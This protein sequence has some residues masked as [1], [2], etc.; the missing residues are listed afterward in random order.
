MPLWATL[1]LPTTAWHAQHARLSAIAERAAP[2]RAFA[3]R[4]LDVAV[5]LEIAG[6]PT[7]GVAHGSEWLWWWCFPALAVRVGCR[8][9][10]SQRSTRGVLLGPTGA[11]LAS[12]AEGIAYL[13]NVSLR[14]GLLESL[15]AA[16]RAMARHQSLAPFAVLDAHVEGRRADGAWIAGPLNSYRLF[17]CCSLFAGLGHLLD[18]DEVKRAAL[19]TL[20][21]FRA[22]DALVYH[23]GGPGT[24]G[25]DEDDER[26]RTPL[27]D[28]DWRSL[29]LVG[30]TKLQ[31]EVPLGLGSGVG[32]DPDAVFA[33]ID[34]NETKALDR[35]ELLEHLLA[36][37]QE[38]ETIAELFAV[39]DSNGDGFITPDE[40]RAGFGAFLEMCG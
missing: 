26:R 27:C 24:A 35:T 11:D 36:S 8:S 30:G 32:G 23:G 40:F 34:T 37:G 31:W 6:E 9:S 5:T 2:S 4:N 17:C 1:A 22:G 28:A 18:D 29:E 16:Q 13:H 39:L 7:S 3:L 19:Q 25:Y 20:R 12:A 21:H 14:D 33:L 10:V 38:P 15:K